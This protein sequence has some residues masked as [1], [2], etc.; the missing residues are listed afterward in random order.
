MRCNRS[1]D[2]QKKGSRDGLSGLPAGAKLRQVSLHPPLHAAPDR[3]HAAAPLHHL[4]GACSPVPVM[5]VLRAE[6][7][8]QHTPSTICTDGSADKSE[9]VF[10]QAATMSYPLL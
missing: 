5:Q 4:R 9:L 6:Y 10:L 7:V 1:A 3:K 2:N 8:E